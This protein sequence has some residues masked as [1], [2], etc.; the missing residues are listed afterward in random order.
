MKNLICKTAGT[1]II[2]DK[3]ISKHDGN[4][5][6]SSPSSAEDMF[7]KIKKSYGGFD[8]VKRPNG[9]ITKGKDYTLRMAKND[10]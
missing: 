6:E 9:K 4:L 8:Q 2:T 3:T 10:F 5:Y 1:V 7:N